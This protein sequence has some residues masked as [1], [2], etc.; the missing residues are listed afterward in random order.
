MIEPPTWVPMA[1]GTMRA[2]TAAAE[3]DE[4][5][6]QGVLRRIVSAL[7]NPNG[8][9]A[10]REEITVGNFTDAD[11]NLA[12]WR[13]RDAAG[14]EF[15]LSG[16]VP[17]AARLTFVMVAN[18]MPLNNTG[19]TVTLLDPDGN[20]AHTVTYTSAQAGSGATVTFP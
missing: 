15:P 11:L 8:D 13:L 16:V 10:R 19:D 4:E 6:P 7:P 20:V 1:A 14:N 17:P 9:D 5:P 2:A 12:G 18:T 3:P